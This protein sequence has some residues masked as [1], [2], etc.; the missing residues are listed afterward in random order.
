MCYGS[1]N[2]KPSGEI[3]P[4]EGEERKRGRESREEGCIKIRMSEK[5]IGNHIIV[6]L[7]IYMFTHTY[8]S[9][10]IHTYIMKL[11]HLG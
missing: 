9:I 7:L 3:L 1:E 2:E 5:N 8:M 10:W 11:F 6:Y 4:G